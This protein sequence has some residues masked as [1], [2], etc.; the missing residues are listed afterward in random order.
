MVVVT[1]DVVDVGRN[2]HFTDHTKLD[3]RTSAN[4]EVF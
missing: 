1:F 2:L 3:R 4:D